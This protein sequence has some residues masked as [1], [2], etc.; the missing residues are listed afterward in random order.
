MLLRMER[1]KP[2]SALASESSPCLVTR[3]F[4]PSILAAVRRGKSKSSLPLGPSTRTLWPLTS[5]F[6]FSGMVMGCFPIRDINQQLPNIAEKFSA[7]VTFAGLNTGHKPLRRRKDRR[8]QS[9]TDTGNLGR[10]DI[11]A[12]SG[13]TDPA[14]PFNDALAAFVLQLELDLFAG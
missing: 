6:T 8:T 1:L 14:Q 5:T 11:A 9:S 13:R 10:P 12:Q 2:C 4:L 7:D 3:I